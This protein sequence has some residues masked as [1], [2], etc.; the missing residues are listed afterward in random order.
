MNNTEVKV[1]LEKPHDHNKCQA[2]NGTGVVLYEKLESALEVQAPFAWGVFT[3]KVKPCGKC[4]GT[5]ME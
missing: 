4:Q 1:Q 2:C 3:H 5:G